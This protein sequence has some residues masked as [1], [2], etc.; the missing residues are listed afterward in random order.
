MHAHSHAHT[1]THT[2]T[3]ARTHAPTHARTHARTHSHTELCLLLFLLLCALYDVT[4]FITLL[5]A[6]GKILLTPHQKKLLR[7]SSTGECV[8]LMMTT[9]A[10]SSLFILWFSGTQRRRAC[11]HGHRL[12]WH[13]AWS[14]VL[15]PL[16]LSFS[17]YMYPLLLFLPSLK[18]GCHG[19]RMRTE[20][21]FNS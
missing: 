12:L 11:M 21:E 1:L 16:S 9:T 18:V 4:L 17:F 14:G 13:I 20:C 5:L 15:L 2:H 8:L 19:P 7:V 3:H 6:P 10:V